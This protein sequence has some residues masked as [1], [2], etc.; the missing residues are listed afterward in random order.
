MAEVLNE[1]LWLKDAGVT[2]D[3]KN[4]NIYKEKQFNLLS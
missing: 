2:A 1:E 4:Y 3:T